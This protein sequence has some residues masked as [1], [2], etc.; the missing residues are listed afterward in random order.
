MTADEIQA[1]TDSAR[2]NK[3]CGI[4]INHKRDKP[5]HNGASTVM[6]YT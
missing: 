2:M 3:M 1:E 6:D 4:G 5:I